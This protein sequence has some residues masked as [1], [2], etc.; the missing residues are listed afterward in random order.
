MVLPVAARELV[1]VDDSCC[2]VVGGS[3]MTFVVEE[4]SEVLGRNSRDVV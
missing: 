1:V 2:A 4:V 3:I